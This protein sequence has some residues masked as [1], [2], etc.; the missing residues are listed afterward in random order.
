MSDVLISL[1]PIY[2]PWIIFGI[3]ALESAGVPLPGET[4]L[5]A[6]AL[7]A[8]TTGQINIVV[9]VAAAAAGAI[10]GDGMGYMVGRRLGLPFL[11]RYGRYIRLD[12][13]R[14]LIGRY[15]FFQYGNAVVFFGRFIAVLRMFAALLA[16]ANCMP[17]SRFFFF[18]I[19]GGVCWACLF[20]FGAYAVGG[21]IYKISGVLSVISLVLFIAAGYAFSIFIRRNEVTLRRRA[22]VVLSDHSCG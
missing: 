4:V 16:G 12:E 8:A 6:A 22:E 15:L 7:L 18:N 11:R 14:L 19:T 10:V 1:I 5:I 2:G 17:P 20:G 9:V 3:V 13:D 21:E